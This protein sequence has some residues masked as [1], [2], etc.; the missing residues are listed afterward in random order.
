MQVAVYFALSGAILL[1]LR[2]IFGRLA[3]RGIDPVLGTAATALV[4][5]VVLA[6]ISAANGDFTQ[7]WP[8]WGLPL[9]NIAFAG[10]LRITVA[11]TLLF[12]AIKH[13]GA[14]RASSLAATNVFFAILLGRLFLDEIL[15]L[16]RIS[17]AIFIVAG[18]VLIARSHT[19]AMPPES[20]RNYIKG[21]SLALTSALAFGSSSVFARPAINI[22]ASPILANFYANA[23]ALLSYLPLLRGRPLRSGLDTWSG[24][25]WVLIAFVGFVVSAGTTCA[26]FAL[27]N[28]PVVFVQP[29]S[30]SRPLFV[31]TISWLFFQFHEQINWRVVTGAACIVGGTVL[32]ILST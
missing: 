20:V 23:F 15:T 32:L 3:M 30:Q 11:R 2:D 29:I 17:G 27:A 28:A 18:C 25:T 22:F 16:P 6:V 10:V 14:A 5:Q 7:P 4:G 13:A 12:T 26:Y 31:V 21:V 8:G 19:K 1:A 9:L 24:L